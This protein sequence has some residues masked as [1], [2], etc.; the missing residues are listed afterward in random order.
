MVLRS[1]WEMRV[2]CSIARAPRSCRVT[3]RRSKVHFSDVHSVPQASTPLPTDL[4][5]ILHL[6]LHRHLNLG[7][8]SNTLLISW[9]T[10][11]GKEQSHYLDGTMSTQ[12]TRQL[13]FLDI[14]AEI[15]ID[16]Y[17]RVF[18]NLEPIPC[19]S[20]YGA[21]GPRT[22]FVNSSAQL[23]WCCKTI[24]MEARTMLFDL[25][26]FELSKPGDLALLQNL[27]G[28]YVSRITWLSF[29]LPAQ[30]DTA[31]V[32]RLQ[33]FE[34]LNYVSLI[35]WSEYRCSRISKRGVERFAV[36]D[37]DWFHSGL[38]ELLE[39][40]PEVECQLVALASTETGPHHDLTHLIGDRSFMIVEFDFI[41][42]EHDQ[43][44]PRPVFYK[45]YRDGKEH[46]I[47][48]E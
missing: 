47:A 35:G 4:S 16:V 26:K 21:G 19:Y 12:S 7:R 36:R 18:T 13:G 23:L 27:A 31:T 39:D 14:P 15:R 3:S 45:A 34:S 40:R 32:N 8:S 1:D 20:L 6:S 24:Y 42:A 22:F 38:S 2:L 28:P 44:R 25:N 11:L 9:R 29:K 43:S 17:H 46:G 37:I 48:P 33:S 41:I 5:L 10:L 30:I